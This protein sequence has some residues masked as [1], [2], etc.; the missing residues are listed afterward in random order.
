M[1]RD[2]GTR[3]YCDCPS[4]CDQH[5]AEGPE[6]CTACDGSGEGPHDGAVC[7]RCRGRCIEDGEYDGPD[8]QDYERDEE[9]YDPW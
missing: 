6:F 9:P 8:S 3:Q 4:T 7:G 2:A 5:E 1:M